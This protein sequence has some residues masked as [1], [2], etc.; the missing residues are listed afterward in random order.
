MRFTSD[1]LLHIKPPWHLSLDDLHLHSAATAAYKP[2]ASLAHISLYL[3]H[4][5]RVSLTAAFPFSI[6]LFIFSWDQNDV[7]GGGICHHH[8]LHCQADAIPYRLAQLPRGMFYR[9]LQIGVAS[10]IVRLL[11]P[12]HSSTFK[13][14]TSS[15][16]QA[17]RLRP[18]QRP[19][20]SA[21]MVLRFCPMQSSS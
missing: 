2:S 12:L 8:P 4:T 20:L 17:S 15:S 9:S 1:L 14:C 18:L 6:F 16:H 5:L 3:I 13:V 7:H 11:T 21:P 10:V 19:S